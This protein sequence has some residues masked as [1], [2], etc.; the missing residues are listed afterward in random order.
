MKF[1]FVCTH[2]IQNL[3]PLFVE[4]EKKK[5]IDFKVIYWDKMDNE[6]FDP[7]FNQKINFGIDSFKKY[8]YD[9]FFNNKKST[10]EINTVSNK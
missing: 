6:H 4:L 8:N 10:G 1:L 5:E 9:Y 7:F 3:I 2:Q